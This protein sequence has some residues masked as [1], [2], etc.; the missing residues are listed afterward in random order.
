MPIDKDVDAREVVEDQFDD[1]IFDRQTND[2]PLE[3]ACP[4][5]EIQ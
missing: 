2:I 3:G 1:R 5:V 4:T